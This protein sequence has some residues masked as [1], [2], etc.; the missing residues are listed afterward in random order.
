MVIIQQEKEKQCFIHVIALLTLY[1]II[2][3]NGY[4][5]DLFYFSEREK[6]VFCVAVRSEFQK[7]K[8]NGGQNKCK[9]IMHLGDLKMRYSNNCVK[10]LIVFFIN[11]DDILTPNHLKYYFCVSSTASF[12]LA[13]QK[14]F[15]FCLQHLEDIT[16][17]NIF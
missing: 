16:F 9:S 10:L 15:Y 1:C 7:E 4:R 11:S 5:A 6:G 12:L 13:C 8:C 17:N 3:R 14:D 2:V